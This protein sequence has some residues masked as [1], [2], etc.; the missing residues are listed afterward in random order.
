M[1]SEKWVSYPKF[2]DLPI[3]QR[4]YILCVYPFTDSLYIYKHICMCVYNFYTNGSTCFTYLCLFLSQNLRVFLI[5]IYL[6]HF[7][8]ILFPK[9][10]LEHI[11]FLHYTFDEHLYWFLFSVTMNCSAMITQVHTSLCTCVSVS[12]GINS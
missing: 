5:H 12:A 9:I 3:A 6:I 2:P 8:C 1:Y 7:N 10:W 11:L 4:Q